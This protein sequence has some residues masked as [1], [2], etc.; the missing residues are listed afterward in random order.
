MHSSCLHLRPDESTPLQS[1]GKQAETITIPPQQFYDVASAPTKHEDVSGERL[2]LKHVL[3]L[4]TQAIKTAAQIRYPGCD[5]DPGP[6]RKLDHLRRLSRI[7]RTKEG[8]APLST[9]IIARPG[10]SM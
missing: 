7:N 10:S 5:P 9:L 4:R 6:N 2:L 8:S 3:H 1:L